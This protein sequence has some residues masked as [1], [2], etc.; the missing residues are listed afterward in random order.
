MQL[1]V[2][3][4][5]NIFRRIWHI[6]YENKQI[7]RILKIPQFF[8]IIKKTIDKNWWKNETFL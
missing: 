2:L 4:Y 6:F 5:F 1:F 3:F 8:V 7:I